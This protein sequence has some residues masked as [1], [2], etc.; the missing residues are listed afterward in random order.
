MIN[1]GGID[2]IGAVDKKEDIKRHPPSSEIFNQSITYKHVQIFT[3]YVL[4]PLSLDASCHAIA[5]L[6]LIHDTP[7]YVDPINLST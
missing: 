3:N 6:R 1:A 5:L 4:E 2:D 7:K